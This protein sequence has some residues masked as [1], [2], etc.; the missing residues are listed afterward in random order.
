MVRISGYNAINQIMV[1]IK[2]QVGSEGSAM[3]I[4]M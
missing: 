4:I 3:T 1:D 2:S